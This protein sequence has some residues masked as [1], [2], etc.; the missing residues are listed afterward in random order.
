[1]HRVT[2]EGAQ[3]QPGL[4]LC[5]QHDRSARQVLLR[6]CL[7]I[8]ALVSTHLLE[9]ALLTHIGRPICVSVD[10]R[11]AFCASSPTAACE[12]P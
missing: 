10:M 6:G 4:K 5:T 9:D 2:A 3:G 7:C 1:M 12:H 8:W 11:S